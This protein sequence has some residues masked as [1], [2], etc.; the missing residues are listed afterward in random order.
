M[1]NF[2]NKILS[3][4]QVLSRWPSSNKLGYGWLSPEGEFVS[5]TPSVN[6][7]EYM[8]GDILKKEYPGQIEHPEKKEAMQYLFKKGWVRVAFDSMDIENVKDAKNSVIEH[9]SKFDPKNEIKIHFPN[10]EHTVTMDIGDFLN[11][12]HDQGFSPFR[13]RH[14]L[15]ASLTSFCDRSFEIPSLAIYSKDGKKFYIDRRLPTDFQ[16]QDPAIF[17]LTHE[18]TEKALRDRL[19]FDYEKA[20]EIAT[21][22][23]KCSVE[24]TG[25]EWIEYQQWVEEWVTKLGNTAKKENMPPD[26]AEINDAD[27]KNIKR[28]VFP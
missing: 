27:G 9:L 11:E 24:Q 1:A 22:A 4:Y 5:L 19:G 10:L 28:E 15:A 21:C 2:K 14:W 26:I 7:H 23:E 18:I 20:H 6:T 13:R 17:L 3:K 12:I 25:L 16:G 8:A